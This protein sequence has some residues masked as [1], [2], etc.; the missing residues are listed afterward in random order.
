MDHIYMFGV[1]PVSNEFL[2]NN[3]NTVI[4]N[5]EIEIAFTTFK[6]LSPELN[7]TDN[8]IFI[9]RDV[10]SNT[11]IIKVIELLRKNIAPCYLP[12]TIDQERYEMPCLDPEDL[13]NELTN[14]LYLPLVAVKIPCLELTRNETIITH[15]SFR[16]FLIE[17]YL[18]S[19]NGIG[20][21]WKVLDKSIDLTNLDYPTISKYERSISIRALLNI[22]NIEEL[23]PQWD[24]KS[25]SNYSASFCYLS[26][27]TSFIKLESYDGATECLKLCDKFSDSPRS[28]ALK[29][30]VAALKGEHL[31]AVAHLVSSLQQYEIISNNSKIESNPNI[32]NCLKI[33]LKSLNQHDNRRALAMFS[34]AIFCYDSFYQECGIEP[35]L[36]SI[37]SE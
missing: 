18:R 1:S 2:E 20:D 12:I 28:L 4:I 22:F 16:T 14:N 32:N 23:Y 37:I 6:K 10:L 19:L 7:L 21:E 29:G 27:A 33:G 3:S 35:L 31:G 25:D 9:D 30:I 13:I 36:S 11:D 24:W 17:S 26:L 15:F 5:G 8:I 34:K